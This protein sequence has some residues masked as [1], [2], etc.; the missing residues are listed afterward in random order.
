ML[1]TDLISITKS[2]NTVYTTIGMCH[3]LILKMG[4]IARV[5]TCIYTSK[6]THL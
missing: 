4:T 6:F 3:A 1:R 5:Y 2:F